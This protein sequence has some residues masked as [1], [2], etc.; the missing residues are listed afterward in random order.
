VQPNEGPIDFTK[1]R[2]PATADH[3]ARSGVGDDADVGDFRQGSPSSRWAL[4]R[5]LVGRAIGESV[6]TS[7]LVVGLVILA[8]AGLLWWAGYS[9]L[10]VLVALVG[11]G[12]LGMR[13]L[14][15]ALLRR[16]TQSAHY[17]GI[18]TRLRSLVRETRSD[19]QRELRRIGLPGRVM[20][21]PLLGLRLARRRRRADTL[22]RLRAFE[23]ENVVPPARLDELHMLLRS[24]ASGPPPPGAR[25]RG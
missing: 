21:L 1:Y 16:L 20:T 17:A 18:E 10:A 8:G 12:V 19:V 13:S 3:A 11:I 22:E 24:A 15:R 6:G 7:L 5:Y 9:V 4:S 14:L 25:R 2:P 23:V